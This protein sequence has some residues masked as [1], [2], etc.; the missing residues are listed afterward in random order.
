MILSK[1]E[2]TGSSGG[3]GGYDGRKNSP[4]QFNLV[5]GYGWAPFMG[6]RAQR[7]NHFGWAKY[8]SSLD[9]TPHERLAPGWAVGGAC[10]YDL[11]TPESAGRRAS[12]PIETL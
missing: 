1:I 6:K 4:P 3:R 5:Q 2:A 8:R 11:L 10:A 7:A 9:T 12:A